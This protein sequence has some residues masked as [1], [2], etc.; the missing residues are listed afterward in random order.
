MLR[1]ALSPPPQ[2]RSTSCPT[3][4]R[5]D[6]RATPT[7]PPLAQP[8][9]PPVPAASR[10]AATANAMS[11]TAGIS[12]LSATT[13]HADA[14]A[15]G[16][17][18]GGRSAIRGTAPVPE[19]QSQKRPA[20]DRPQPLSSCD[21]A[22]HAPCPAGSD[23]PVKNRPLHESGE[24]PAVC[25][26][27]AG[28]RARRALGLPDPQRPCRFRQP[29]RRA[30]VPGLPEPPVP[31]LRPGIG[32]AVFPHRPSGRPGPRLLARTRPAPGVPALRGRALPDAHPP[33][34]RAF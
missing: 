8:S 21:P 29:R 33:S 32:R 20:P 4:A 17:Q 5:R 18:D 11:A 10:R 13:A 30:R 15:R 16:H 28:R 3:P 25:A 34:V 1:P 19:R 22:G 9:E 23:Q 14:D 24:T 7:A 6:D 27:P 26:P 12:R 2:P 31:D